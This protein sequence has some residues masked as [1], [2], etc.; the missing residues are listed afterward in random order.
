MQVRASAPSDPWLP[1]LRPEDL[2]LP[3]Q[4]GE[5]PIEQHRIGLEAEK[6]GVFTD[7]TP[8]RYGAPGA[9]VVTV[10]EALLANGRGWEPYREIADG[11]LVALQR[12]G[13]SV[14]LE[15]GGQLEL[16]GSPM[17]D[18]HQ[19]VEELR[20]HFA[21]LEPISTQLGL[22]WLGLG[23]HPLA[24]Q[25]QLDWVPKRRYPI[26][27]DYLPGQ[28]SGAHDMMRRTATVQVNLDFSGEQDAMRKLRL[29]MAL[30][31]VVAALFSNAPFKEGQRTSMLSLRQDVWHHMDPQRSGL[32]QE[33]WRTASPRYE[34]YARWAAKAG[35]FLFLRWGSVVANT[36]QS[37]NSFMGDGY[38]GHRATLADWRLHL[39]TLFPEVRLKSTIE[40]RCCDSVPFELAGALPAL[41]V[42]L[43]YDEAS[44]TAAEGMASSWSLEHVET[45]RRELV[46]RGLH[47]TLGGRPLG[48]WA[49]EL[50]TLARRGLERRRRL[51]H[52]GADESVHLIALEKL[53]TRRL[54]PAEALLEALGDGDVT[55]DGLARYAAAGGGLGAPR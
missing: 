7:G 34:D 35:M 27:R 24:R 40:V 41:L 25:A 26:M 48:E 29:L 53:L 13:A 12:E 16:S 4:E 30:T 44:L 6:F 31:P 45:A 3:F 52:N 1:E 42:G 17:A 28:G 11:P 38:Q 55:I 46:T 18:V 19:V 10:L 2:I 49:Q 36:G 33:L 39:T 20:S 43:V 14:T 8:L 37:F 5:T 15:P 32:V 23:F 50:V 22:H 51:D 21:E 54:T 47:A 9:S